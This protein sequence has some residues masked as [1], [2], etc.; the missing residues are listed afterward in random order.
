[1]TSLTRPLRDSFADAEREAALKRVNE[2]LVEAR[3]AAENVEW[4]VDLTTRRIVRKAAKRH[5]TR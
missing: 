2:L 5:I 3:E 1:M 4:V